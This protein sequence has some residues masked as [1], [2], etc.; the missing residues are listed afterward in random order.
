MTIS[1]YGQS[2]FKIQT[3]TK[4]G[5]EE[6]TII[7]DPFD[8]TIGLR[9]PQGQ[10]DIVTISH[11]HPAHNSPTLLKGDYFTIDSPGEYS[12][13]GISIEGIESFHDN[14]EGADRGRNTIFVIESEDVR[15]CHLGDLGHKLNEKQLEKINGI[16]ILMIPIGGTTTLDG[17]GAE[18]VI[19]QIE[20]KLIIPM[21]YKVKGLTIDINDEQPF[22]DEM[23]NCPKE[24]IQKLVL[25]KKEIEEKENEIVLMSILNT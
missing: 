20:P 7:T 23:G 16:D 22:C 21:H 10:T 4:R 3:R 18:Q 14:Q 1:W 25:K 11:N 13:K 15:I 24:K 12:I 8:K 5:G 17:K 6:V 2:C 9:P 19:G